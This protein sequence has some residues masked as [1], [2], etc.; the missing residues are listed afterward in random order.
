MN[1]FHFPRYVCQEPFQLF[2]TP[3]EVILDF[4][5]RTA[6]EVILDFDRRLSWL[7]GTLL[8]L[9][10]SPTAPWANSG[11]VRKLFA[12]ETALFHNRMFSSGSWLWNKGM[13]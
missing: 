5:R 12:A 2:T 6:G 11:S 9:L 4:D 3:G 10:L 13:T 1:H 8:L 7:N